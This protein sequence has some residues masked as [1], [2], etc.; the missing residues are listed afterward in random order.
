MNGTTRFR[1]LDLSGLLLLGMV[2]C[3]LS[4]ALPTPTPP[5]V[6]IHDCLVDVSVFPQGWSADFSPHQYD[7]PGRV[8]PG[9]AQEGVSIQ[10]RSKGFGALAHHDVLRY[11][12]KQRA[13]DEYH[14]QQPGVFFSAGRL[15]PWEA[16]EALSY[17]SPI[18]DQ[19]RLACADI[20]VA[21]RFR[22]CTAQGQYDEHLSTFST[23]VSPDYMTYAN[24]ERVLKAIDERMAHCV[25]RPIL[26]TAGTR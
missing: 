18:A 20:E 14:R 8:L 17:E 24:L 5:A 26:V 16:P 22:L 15:T 21:G 2:S 10:L 9:R 4:R 13:A 23:W 11:Q 6:P 7:L 19:F 25:G 1:L 12:N 3:S